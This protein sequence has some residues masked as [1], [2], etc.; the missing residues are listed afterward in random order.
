MFTS[1]RFPGLTAGNVMPWLSRH[2]AWPFKSPLLRG[3]ARRIISGVAT[4]E[5]Q[6]IGAFGCVASYLLCAHE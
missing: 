5:Q 6:S 2:E 1:N 3:T 4:I